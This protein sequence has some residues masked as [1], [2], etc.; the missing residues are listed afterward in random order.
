MAVSGFQPKALTKGYDGDES[1]SR[2]ERIETDKSSVLPSLPENLKVT[3]STILSKYS[4][5]APLDI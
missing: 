3:V 2:E 4:R 1:T 5:R